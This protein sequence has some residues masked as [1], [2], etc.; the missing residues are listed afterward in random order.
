MHLKKDTLS[1]L[2]ALFFVL[3]L[4]STSTYASTVDS[5][6]TEKPIPSLHYYMDPLK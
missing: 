4:L 5:P 6:V 3:Q 2:L 1:F